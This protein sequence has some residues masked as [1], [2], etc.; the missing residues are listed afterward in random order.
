MATNL[1]QI[2]YDSEIKQRLQA[3]R[4]R[5]RKIA[6][7]DPPEHFH[8][9]VERLNRDSTHEKICLPSATCFSKLYRCPPLLL[10]PTLPLPMAPMSSILPIM[11]NFCLHAIARRTGLTVRIVCAQLAP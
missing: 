11:D 5:L 3:E 9:P 10:Q 7:L 4:A 1:V 8:R 2:E 6:G